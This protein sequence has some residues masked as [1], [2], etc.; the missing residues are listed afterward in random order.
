[1]TSVDKR[2]AAADV[3][4]VMMAHDSTKRVTLKGLVASDVYADSYYDNRGGKSSL[5]FEGTSAKNDK[6]TLKKCLDLMNGVATTEEKTRLKAGKSLLR[7][8]DT[9]AVE[10]YI[11]CVHRLCDLYKEKKLNVPPKLAQALPPADSRRK[12]TKLFVTALG[13]TYYF[14]AAE[15]LNPANLQAW[16]LKREQ[17]AA[18]AAEAE[19]EAEADTATAMAAATAEAAAPASGQPAGW[20]SHNKR[21]RTSPAVEETHAPASSSSMFGLFRR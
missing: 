12:L 10:I 14:K 8:N 7:D 11:L 13:E 2:L 15:E 16:R 20:G 3:F 4:N 1:M 19:T 6:S 18:A 9:L 17:A 5:R 21:A